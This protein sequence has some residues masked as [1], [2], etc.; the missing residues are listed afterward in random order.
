LR[1]SSVDMSGFGSSNTTNKPGQVSVPNGEYV[2]LPGFF[3]KAET[4]AYFKA[5]KAEV[6]WRQES[7]SMYG[8]QVLFPRLMAWYGDIGRPYSFSGIRLEP[9]PWTE[10]LLEI[11]NTIEPVAQTRFNSVLL[12]RYRNG[13]D[14]ISW[15]ADAEN[16]LGANPVIGSV[17]FGAVRRFQLRHSRT[18]E[19]IELELGDGS[20]LVMRGEMQ[21]FWQHQVPKTSRKV[22]ER[23]NLTFRVIK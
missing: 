3:T 17:S 23:I 16:E 7:M 19:K 5:L 14:S 20:L 18:R 21:H 1:T 11:R 15:H 6:R 12:N 10:E 22:G 4:T 8:K 13:N 2:Y 9:L